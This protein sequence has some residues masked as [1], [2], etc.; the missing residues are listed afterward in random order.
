LSYEVLPAGNFVREKLR[1]LV[2]S[3]CDA[4]DG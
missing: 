1:S 2:G 3:C 4:H